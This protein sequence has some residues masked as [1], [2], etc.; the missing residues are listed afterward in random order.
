[1]IT[2]WHARHPFGRRRMCFARTAALHGGDKRQKVKAS[3][4][5]VQHQQHN[6]QKC[7]KTN[8]RRTMT[9][10]R[11]TQDRARQVQDRSRQATTGPRQVKTGQ[12]RPKTGPRLAQDRPKTEQD[13]PK[14]AQNRPKSGS[15]SLRT[16]ADPAP[17]SG[18]LL[19]CGFF[20]RL[21]ALPSR[22]RNFASKKH[23]KKCEN[24]WFWLPNPLPKRGQNPFNIDVPKNM[25][26]FT[27]FCSIFAACC[28]SQHRFRI[29]FLQYKM[30]LGR[31]LQVAF[32]MDLG[33][34]KLTKNP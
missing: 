23:R 19:L 10:P 2:V 20:F 1:M 25:R 6:V 31:F 14:T 9:G 28:K 34:K 13:R 33:S 21:F 4:A 11:Q 30:G 3:R 12:D 5:F 8:A 26:F 18:N 17:R 22:N 32:C 15:R 7:P 27:D 16:T 24:Q 29:G